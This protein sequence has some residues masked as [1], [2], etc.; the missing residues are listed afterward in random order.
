MSGDLEDVPTI[1][2]R[3][4]AIVES[5]LDCVISIDALGNIVEFNPA[6]E[7]TLG[8]ARGDVI[9]REL[10]ALIIPAAYR[11][12]HRR[13]LAHYLATGEST[14]LG[15]RLELTA[16]R[17]DGAEIPV[18]LA[19]TR[20]SVGDRVL[21][22][23]YLRDLTER[24][25]L[26]Q[27]RNARLAVAH[28]L[29]GARS[30]GDGVTGVLRSVCESL[31]WD[32]GLFWAQNPLES[33]LTYAHSWHRDDECLA[34]YDQVCRDYRFERG[35]GVPG[36]VWASGQPLWILDVTAESN[37]PRLQHAVSCGIRSALALPV[38]A[39]DRTVGVMEF[40]ATALRP[41][42]ADLLEMMATVG[43][44]VAQFFE[45]VRSEAAL[46][47]SETRFRGLMEQ[48]PFSIQLLSPDGR[49]LRVNKSWEELWGLT[50]EHLR[51][52][53]MLEDKQ[54]EA[55]G[56]L[57]AIKR[58]FE[59]EAS[60]IPVIRY[61]PNETLADP[62]RH[63]DPVRCIS[64]VA[65]PLKDDAGH[66][67]EVVLVHSDITARVA[68]EN[69]LKD[70][71]SELETRVA[72]RTAEL[73]RT[74]EFLK[75]LLEN[76]QTG[77][78]A[79]DESGVLTLFN[80]V[81]R[82]LHGLPLDALPADAWAGR[83]GLFHADGITPLAK[84]DVPLYRALQGEHVQ[85]AEMVIRPDAAPARTVR[86]SGQAILDPHG[87][88]LGAVVSMEDV[89]ARKQAEEGLLT[90]HRE[91]ERRVAERTAELA[92]ANDALRQSEEKLRDADRRKDEF[93]ATLAHELRNPLAPISNA[94]QILKTQGLD[95]RTV[96][97]SRDLMERQV[98]HMVRLVDDLL[99]VSR[100]MR[101]KI[102]LQREHLDLATI[103]TRA[104]E[105]V[106]P[107]VAAQAHELVVTLP[108]A[109]LVVDGDPVRLV[110]IVS[111]LLVNAAK[112]TPRGGRIT[113]SAEREGDVAVLSVKDS[114]I[115]MDARTL[116]HIFEL[117][118]QADSG[119]SHAQGGLGVGLTLAKTLVEMHGGTI[120]ASSAGANQGSEL[121]VRL[122][123]ATP[124]VGDGVQP[125][126]AAEAA[127]HATAR[128]LVLVVD[129]N[130]DAA[131]T[132]GML[133]ELRGYAV[134]VAYGGVEAVRMASELMPDGVFLDIGMPELDGY[135]VARRLQALPGF[136]DV[137]LA[138]LTGWGQREDRQRTAQAGFSHHLVKPPEPEALQRVLTAIENRTKR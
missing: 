36:S 106:Q 11:E 5:A 12:R 6:A 64:A 69:A 81:T 7:R 18:E 133:L 33:A 84:D 34:A 87:K 92:H 86:A 61:D 39:G 108:A 120:A 19:I 97:R 103:A 51:G 23:A 135:E 104:V 107:L 74:N 32:A 62:S 38:I 20:A 46:R 21:F 118:V 122:P 45:R 89:T 55:K 85:D 8:Y 82:A 30:V 76:V 134:R 52:Y 28:V 14:I 105:T 59:G 112:Y 116:P 13:G 96:E 93:L 63:R 78:V 58:A 117:F 88:K 60:D 31:G 125:A 40:F 65:Y 79:C 101:G 130:R 41:P 56:I 72:N 68:A 138:A 126:H 50:L 110:Q 25:R 132:L 42:D 94:L 3:T 77:V 54:L 53:N 113:L 26:E 95:A 27:L 2:A 71:H 114:G 131:D 137:V 99:D 57:P 15:K 80:R 73:T 111:N 136:G 129:D 83:Y 91:L 119:A 47:D 127:Q 16:L 29:G 37:F 49:T 66:V 115:G 17:A 102:T 22:T 24:R 43:S 100:V 67:R 98:H 44:F 35:V 70:A 109:P 75:A 121:V 90:A 128:H 48:A 123:L 1:D 9:G 10:A 4:S 124:A